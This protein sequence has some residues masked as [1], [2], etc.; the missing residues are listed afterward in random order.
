MDKED[1][2]ADDANK[3]QKNKH[4]VSLAGKILYIV[5]RDLLIGDI[6]T[7]H[8]MIVIINQGGY[9]YLSCAFVAQILLT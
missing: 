6:N 2:V 1:T 3:L 9:A 4:P 7:A 5:I 8:P